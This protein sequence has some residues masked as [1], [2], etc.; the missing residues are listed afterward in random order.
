MIF[1]LG[2]LSWL[3][4]VKW[5]FFPSAYLEDGDA[6]SMGLYSKNAQYWWRVFTYQIHAQQYVC[7]VAMS[8]KF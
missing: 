4:E 1:Y 6:S 2:V 5:W 7:A 3:L 8:F